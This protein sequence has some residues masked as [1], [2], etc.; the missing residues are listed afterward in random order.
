MQ[1][2]AHL[3]LAV[4]ALCCFASIFAL[5]MEGAVMD[6][7]CRCLNTVSSQINSQRFQRIEILPPGSHCRN[8]EIIITLKDKK[9]VCVD[10]EANWVQKI[11]NKFMKR[12]SIKQ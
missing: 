8:T 10:P 7:D 6:H 9:L 3:L 5:P 12:R 1:L 11:I 2:S 4:T